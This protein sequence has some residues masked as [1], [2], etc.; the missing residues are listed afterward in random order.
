MEPKISVIIPVY[1]TEKYLNRCIESL[2]GQSISD[3]EIIL[4][5]D[6]STDSS[7][8]I[9][10]RAASEDRRIKVIHKKN[11]GQGIAR[12]EGL[13][14]ARGEYIGF[15]DSDDY[16]EKDMFEK[17]YNA[18]KKNDADLVLSGMY[19]VGGN[20]F[21]EGN[22]RSL[23]LSFENETI[24]EGD[25]GRKKLLLGIVG[26]LPTDSRDSLYG[27]STCTNLY[28][29]STIKNNNIRFLSERKILSEDGLFNMDFITHLN[30]AIGISGAWYNYCRNGES[31]SKSYNATRFERSIV[32]LGEIESRLKTLMD[33]SQYEIYLNRLRIGFARILCSQEIMR[34]SYDNV[35]WSD[36]KDRLR[37]I[38]C[39][40]EIRCAFKGYPWYRL[41]P[42]QA[43]FAFLVKHKLYIMQKILVKLRSGQES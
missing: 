35:L 1:N 29:F 3:I 30:R 17:L 5:D 22:A 7:P 38:C 14:I 6:G 24:F 19:F 28:R 37:E 21:D 15:V 11:E 40:G 4:V 8:L 13:N 26:A 9:C 18:A 25:E 39:H 23:Q 12:N 16:V 2:T 43:V 42:K 34:L 36:V 31:V 10:D 20:M 41:P 33:K 27:M 32:F